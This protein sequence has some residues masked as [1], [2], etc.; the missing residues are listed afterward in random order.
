M[1]SSCSNDQQQHPRETGLAPYS[2]VLVWR[3]RFYV[4]INVRTISALPDEQVSTAAKLALAFH[5]IALAHISG[6]KPQIGRIVHGRE[7]VRTTVPLGPYYGKVQSLIAKISAQNRN[8][9]PPPT[10]AQQAL[11]RM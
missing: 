5:C 2:E 3:R 6:R 8:P 7:Q 1:P 4:P 9:I 11:C 10:L